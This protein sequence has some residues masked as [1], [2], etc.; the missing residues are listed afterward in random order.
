MNTL[1]KYLKGLNK[2]HIGVYREDRDDKI[3]DEAFKGGEDYIYEKVEGLLGAYYKG[4]LTLDELMRLC[5][6]LKQ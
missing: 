3:V 5:R 2:I 6:E 4:L 1:F